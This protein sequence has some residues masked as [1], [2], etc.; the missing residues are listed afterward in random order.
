M[1]RIQNKVEVM[2][3]KCKVTVAEFIIQYNPYQGFQ[4]IEH[5]GYDPLVT[6]LYLNVYAKNHAKLPSR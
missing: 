5:G 1:S 3:H 2:S 4:L 6:V